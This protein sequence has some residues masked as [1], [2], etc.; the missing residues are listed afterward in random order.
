MGPPNGKRRVGVRALFEGDPP[1][2]SRLLRTKLKIGVNENAAVSED[3]LSRGQR[4]GG[5]ASSTTPATLE[6]LLAHLFASWFSH[7]LINSF[8]RLGLPMTFPR[9]IDW[10]PA[11]A[12][13]R[14]CC[15]LCRCSSP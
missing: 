14:G 13:D 6:V 8:L 1:Q 5:L 15:R 2:E 4:V 9:G 12:R 11:M 7:L 3:S 10:S